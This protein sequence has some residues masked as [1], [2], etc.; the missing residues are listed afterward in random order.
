VLIS[1]DGASAGKLTLDDRAMLF[2]RKVPNEPSRG[3]VRLEHESISRHHAAVVHSFTGETFVVDLGSRFG[4]TADGEKLVANKYTPIKEGA[5]LVFGASTRAYTLSS[6]PPKEDSDSKAPARSAE[7]KPAGSSSAAT[8]GGSRVAGTAAGKRAVPRPP[9]NGIDDDADPMADYVSAAAPRTPYTPARWPRRALS[10]LL[11]PLLAQE[12]KDEES[13]EDGS[14]AVRGD[15]EGREARRREKERRKEL[16]AELKAA[17]KAE[18]KSEK[19]EEKKAEKKAE[20]KETKRE[21]KKAEKEARKSEKKEAKKGHRKEHREHKTDS[22]QD[23]PESRRHG[24][25]RNVGLARGAEGT[26]S[27][28]DA[29]ERGEKRPREQEP[30]DEAS[31]PASSHSSQD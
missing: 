30:P 5:V 14:G 28:P 15:L 21:T 16:K 4:T 1:K 27:P 3:T 12:D 23:M 9:P 17:V 18:K 25:H 31:T 26:E 19:K 20:K 11:A 13:G 22:K 10:C 24:E 29:E 7:S 2:G 8:V 6:R